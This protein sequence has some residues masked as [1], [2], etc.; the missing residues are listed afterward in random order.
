MCLFECVPY[1]CGCD[2]YVVC[3]LCC[4]VAIMFFVCV[5]VCLSSLLLCGLVLC[6]GGCCCVDVVCVVHMLLRVVV[7]VVCVVVGMMW[8]CGVVVFRVVCVLCPSV[9]CN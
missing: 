7:V 6:D 2:R 1:G 3:R 4:Y 8:L 5:S 9:F